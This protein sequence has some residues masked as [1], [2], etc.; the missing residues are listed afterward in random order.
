MRGRLS[1]SLLY[2][3]RLGT[4]SDCKNS[5]ARFAHIAPYDYYDC[6][7]CQISK[8]MDQCRRC[9]ELRLR[10]D[11][12]RC[13]LFTVLSWQ[14]TRHLSEMLFPNIDFCNETQ[15]FSGQSDL[16]TILWVITLVSFFFVRPENIDGNV[17][18]S[19]TFSFLHC[20]IATPARYYPSMV[21]VDVFQRIY[22]N[23]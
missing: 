20:P 8:D 21:A 7:Q 4:V 14:H 18:W 19:S 10:V 11:S 22:L 2:R 15:A 5:F 12:V 9:L 6:C 13:I 1:C 17:K 23:Q 16:V 3:S